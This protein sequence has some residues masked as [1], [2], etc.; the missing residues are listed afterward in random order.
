MTGIDAV[1]IDLKL[2][3]HYQVCSAAASLLSSQIRLYLSSINKPITA[4]SMSLDSSANPVINDPNSCNS[5]F[6]PT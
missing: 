5:G 4:K 6:Y 2:S 3:R 1:S